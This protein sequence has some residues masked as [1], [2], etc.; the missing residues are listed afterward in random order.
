MHFLSLRT[1]VN[2]TEIY[3]LVFIISILDGMHIVV[4]YFHKK[5]QYTFVTVA[6]MTEIYY[7]IP[8]FSS[9]LLL[10]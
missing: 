6:N 1:G 9:H 7:Q 2:Y 4:T 3:Q 8:M 5:R 10:T